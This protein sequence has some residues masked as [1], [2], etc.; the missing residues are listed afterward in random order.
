MEDMETLFE[1]FSRHA[2][3]SKSPGRTSLLCDYGNSTGRMRATR[4]FVCKNDDEVSHNRSIVSIKEP[5][6]S[7]LTGRI[8]TGGEPHH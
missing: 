7:P 2:S 6:D 4:A 1:R 5:R 8:A 3:N